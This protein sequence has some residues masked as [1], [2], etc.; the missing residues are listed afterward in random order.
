M[1]IF[2]NRLRVEGHFTKQHA[3]MRNTHI[4]VY[5]NCSKMSRSSIFVLMRRIH[6]FTGRPRQQSQGHAY[7]KQSP[8]LESRPSISAEA[9]GSYAV[10]YYYAVA[11]VSR[12]Q[13]F[14]PG[15]VCI[16]TALL[17]SGVR[18]ATKCGW[19]D[20]EGCGRPNEWRITEG[21]CIYWSLPYC[22]RQ[23]RFTQIGAISATEGGRGE[24]ATAG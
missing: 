15:D 20:L 9:A 18:L 23:C 6:V 4:C 7:H 13:W 19:V 21:S 11:A 3:A 10:D 14:P 12:S 17:H 5:A 24:L 16:H 22:C 8:Q 2:P 1:Y